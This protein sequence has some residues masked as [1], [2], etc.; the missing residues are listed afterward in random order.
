MAVARAVQ[1]GA[2]TLVCASTGNT[3][4]SAAAFAA[5]AGLRCVVV[6]PDGKIASG[7]L[8]QAQI[9]GAVVVAVE[10]SFDDA[11]REVRDLANRPGWALVNSV[12]PYRIEGQKTAAYEVAE[13][14]GDAPDWMCLPVG[15]A[16]NITAWWQG[17]NE[18]LSTGEISRLPRILGI[19]AAGAAPLVDGAPVEN[20]ETIATAIRIGRP[21]RGDQA[22]AAIS[23]SDGRIIKRTDG[24]LLDAYQLVAQMSGIFCEPA[25]A[26][27]I[28]GLDWA[29]RE[30]LIS[31]GD[32]VVCVLTGHGLKDPDTAIGLVG[33]NITRVPASAEAIA[34]AAD[35]HG[36]AR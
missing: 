25:S 23:E 9:A 16:G 35:A 4:A 5:A 3:S 33:G 2:H 13:V 15:N 1:S 11:L 36:G 22:L 29:T 26:I 12:N 24:E 17:W 6:I 20:P 7:K 34:A 21:A 27:S 31:A 28:A 18:L 32:R 10:G 30:G 8:V 19:Q 14:L